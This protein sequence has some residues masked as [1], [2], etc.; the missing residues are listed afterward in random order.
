MKCVKCNVDM[1]DE[2]IYCPWCG[3]I[4]QQNN[5]ESSTSVNGPLSNV[6]SNN[7]GSAVTNINNGISEP[8][9]LSGEVEQNINYNVGYKEPNN[10]AIKGKSKIPVLVA[11]ILIVIVLAIASMCG[12]LFINSPK[13]SFY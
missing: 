7:V 13:K 9:R 1:E 2:Y 11:T 5:V 3:D 4:L 8:E 12:Y 6:D 10:I